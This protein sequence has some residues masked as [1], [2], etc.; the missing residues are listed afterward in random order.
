MIERL[1]EFLRRRRVD[2]DAFAAVFD[3]GS[4]DGLQAVELSS[5]FHH[6]E[7]V[8]VECNRETL[9]TCRRNIAQSTRIKLIEKAINSYTGRC[10]FYPIDPARTVT[11]WPDGNPG[12][13]SLFMAT[14]DYPAES[15]VQN[16]VEVDCIRLDDL[17]RQLKINAIDLIWMDLQGAELL[18]LKSAGPLLDTVRYIYTEVS[19]RPIYHGQCLFDDVDAL[20]TARQF[21]RCTKINRERWQQDIIYENAREPF[22]AVCSPPDRG[23]SQ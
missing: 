1:A 5:L 4:R 17:C 23:S 16:K 19:H 7:V 8:A 6:A 20:L 14:G 21:R 15:Y 3:I 22:A 10:A 18:A 2:F 9:E 12:A 11:S 13:S